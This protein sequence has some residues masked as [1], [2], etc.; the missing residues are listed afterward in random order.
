MTILLYCVL[1]S[2]VI[3][4]CMRVTLYVHVL[5][6]NCTVYNV[7]TPL[8]YLKYYLI[9]IDKSKLNDIKDS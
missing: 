9:T 4:V 3:Y 1:F 2:D 6:C 8:S 5:L 7:I